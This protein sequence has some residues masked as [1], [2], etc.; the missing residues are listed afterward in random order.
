MPNPHWKIEDCKTVPLPVGP[1][2]IREQE[3]LKHVEHL[4]PSPIAD[5]PSLD[6][7]AKRRQC[8]EIF[9]DLN[10]TGLGGPG[11]L[12]SQIRS[13]FVALQ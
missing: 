1:S 5:K 11:G 10:R 7:D 2:G 12:F 13:A 8:S 6:L 4:I 3:C 9:G